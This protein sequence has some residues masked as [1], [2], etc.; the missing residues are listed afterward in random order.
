MDRGVKK[1]S[2]VLIKIGEII[3]VS[4]DTENL[5]SSILF[6]KIVSNHFL[7]TFEL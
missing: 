6:T 1:G 2:N 4:Q 7:E 5:R 3:K